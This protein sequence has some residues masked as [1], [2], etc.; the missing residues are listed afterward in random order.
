MCSAPVTN[1]LHVHGAAEVAAV[2][3]LGQPRP[4][5]RGLARAPARRR[6][7]VPLALHVATVGEEKPPAAQALAL[8]A[9]RHRRPRCTSP[10]V[11]VVAVPP[12]PRQP[13]RRRDHNGRRTCVK[14]FGRKKT[15][16]EEN[17]RSNRPVQCKFGSAITGVTGRS[18]TGTGGVTFHSSAI[19]LRPHSSARIDLIEMVSVGGFEPPLFAPRTRRI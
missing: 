19:E 5:A 8:S 10:D 7:A 16:G 6:R 18:R 15:D 1:A 17:A 11:T 13:R 9:L 12:T 4:L 14:D 3:G 2:V